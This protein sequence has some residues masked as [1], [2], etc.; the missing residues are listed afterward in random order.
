MMED[1]STFDQTVKASVPYQGKRPSKGTTRD[2]K[3]IDQI[4]RFNTK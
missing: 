1:P 3:N 2:Y 4:S